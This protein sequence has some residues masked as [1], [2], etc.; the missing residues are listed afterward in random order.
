MA[1]SVSFGFPITGVL[2]QKHT[3]ELA[4]PDRDLLTR[5]ELYRSAAH[6]FRD[7]AARSGFK[8]CAALWDE[9]MSQHSQGRLEAP[10]PLNSD[11]RPTTWRSQRF[12][13]AFRFGVEQA[14]K[15]RACDDLRHILTN[16]A[17]HVA[18]PIQLVSRGHISHLSQ[19]LN[20]GADSW[21]LF[22]ADHEA[23]YKQLPWTSL[24]KTPLSSRCVTPAITC[25]AASLREPWYSCL[26]PP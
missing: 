11:G 26:S 4:K 12:N 2:S 20:N 9:A 7:R 3:F 10:I 22:K 15:L 13:I 21:E 17:C 5:S 19:L 25:G 14:E 18:T 8:N 1:R 16:L 24:T 23:A 6:R